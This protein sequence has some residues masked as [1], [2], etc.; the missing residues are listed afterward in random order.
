MVAPAATGLGI[1]LLV[2]AKSHVTFRLVVTVVLLLALLGSEV[3]AETAEVAVIGPTVT[4]DGTFNTTTMS[5]EVPEPRFALSVQVMVPVAP[6]AGVVHVHPAG[7][8]TDWNVVFAGVAWVSET[9]VAAAG[10]LFVM[11][12]V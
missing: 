10:P 2:M 5:A 4:V 12:C 3:V 7:A 11:L 9:P 1:P 6:T 8:S